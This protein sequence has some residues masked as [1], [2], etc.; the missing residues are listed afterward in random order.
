MDLSLLDEETG[1]RELTG[2]SYLRV[3]AIIR[4]DIEKKFAASLPYTEGLALFSSPFSSSAST[5]S[6]G[7]FMIFSA[8]QV[9]RKNT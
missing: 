2:N 7:F 6:S 4:R 1:L 9:A 3:K 8:F 5:S